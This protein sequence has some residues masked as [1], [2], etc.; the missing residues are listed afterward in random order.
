LNQLSTEAF[1]QQIQSI[2]NDT[3]AWPEFQAAMQSVV[4]VSKFLQD[5]GR[6]PA[7]WALLPGL[8]CQAVGGDPHWV[9]D[10]ASAWFLFYTAAHLLDQVEDQDPIED[11]IQVWAPGVSIN[12]A[13]GMLFAAS[14][15]L[16]RLS[17]NAQ[18]REAA[19]KISEDFFRSLLTMCNGQHLD[20]ISPQPTLEQWMQ[21]ASAK[22]GAFFRLA[23]QAG[24]AVASNEGSIIEAYGEYGFHL[25][26]LLQILDDL[27]DFR[28][29]VTTGEFFLSSASE[30]SLVVTYAREVLP[31]EQKLALFESLP[32]ATQSTEAT[33]QVFDLL[34]HSG[35]E[36]Y[37]DI[38]IERQRSLGIQALQAVSPLS[39]A[40]EILFSLLSDLG[41]D[42]S[43]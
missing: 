11:E 15:I 9:D 41:K 24:A 39:P 37:L 42:S 30:R 20:L 25:G 33:Q 40:G 35:A 28:Q 18:T 34:I 2:W 17:Q 5:P 4:P 13:T 29:A 31:P 10:I 27:G 6:D 12:L 21:I 16:N 22:S 14:Y 38:E 19:H 26:L 23:C 1:Y 7:R 32:I 3:A 8:C 43:A 36:L